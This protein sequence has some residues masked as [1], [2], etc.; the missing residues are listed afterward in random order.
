MALIKESIK[1]LRPLSTNIYDFSINLDGFLTSHENRGAYVQVYWNGCIEAVDNGFFHLE[2]KHILGHAFEVRIVDGLKK[3][4]HFL[5][6]MGL[7]GPYSIFICFQGVK[8]FI[9]AVYVHTYKPNPIIQDELMLPEIIV[10]DERRIDINCA[11]KPAF[12]ILW[13]VAGSAELVLE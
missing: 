7:N 4:I 5:K 9:F 13:S 1:K 2:R 10:K 11:L 8:D 3:Y 6:K 12:D